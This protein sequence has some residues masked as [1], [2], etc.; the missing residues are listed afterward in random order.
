VASAIRSPPP[1]PSSLSRQMQGVTVHS[2]SPASRG[3][4][5]PRH[6]PDTS[7]STSLPFRRV[8]GRPIS[9]EAAADLPREGHVG[10]GP[11]RLCGRRS[12]GAQQ[13]GPV[14]SEDEEAA[15]PIPPRFV[16]TAS[17]LSRSEHRRLPQIR[18]SSLRFLLFRP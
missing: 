2:P 4:S 1:R 16:A 17:F 10:A 12:R 13:A 18:T 6:T 9:G 5:R 14:A 8:C 15:N 3:R 7:R 11:R